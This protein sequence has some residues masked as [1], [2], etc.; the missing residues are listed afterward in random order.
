LLKTI[1]T[2]FSWCSQRPGSRQVARLVTI[3]GLQL[4]LFWVYRIVVSVKA[5]HD[6]T[7]G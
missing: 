3:G 7:G 1:E 6:L 2:R 4:M 5:S